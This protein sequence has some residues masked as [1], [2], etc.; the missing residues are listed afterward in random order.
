[1]KMA[2]NDTSPVCSRC[3]ATN[4]P[5]WRRRENGTIVCL[6]CYAECRKK[7]GESSDKPTS[8]PNTTSLPLKKKR[9]KKGGYRGRSNASTASASPVPT[10]QQPQQNRKSLFKSRVSYQLIK[11]H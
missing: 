4:S 6:E 3:Q 8:E 1:M 11:C 2:S 9:G 10:Y 5:V 7:E